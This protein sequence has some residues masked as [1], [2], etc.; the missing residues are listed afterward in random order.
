MLSLTNIKI[1]I[2]GCKSRGLLES[3]ILFF[4]IFVVYLV[5]LLFS[6]RIIIYYLIVSSWLVYSGK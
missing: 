6:L 2:S 1:I 5:Y 3:Y 4:G